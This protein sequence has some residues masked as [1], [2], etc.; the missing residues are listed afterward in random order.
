M[1]GKATK[2]I[3]PIYLAGRYS[4][5]QELAAN[6][7]AI[8]GLG[9]EVIAEWLTGKHESLDGMVTDAG[10]RDWAQIDR[11]EI[12]ACRTVVAF[13]EEQRSGHSRGG[14][15]VELGMALALRKRVIVV[16]PRENVFCWLP[17]V[18]RFASWEDFYA[19]LAVRIKH[20]GYQ[21]GTA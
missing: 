4:R 5:R 9:I 16:G 19:V 10:Q 11:A 18:D 8:R 13:T 15:H 1:S 14:R 3:G 21:T 20:L 6:A 7:E 17:E 2:V 12:E